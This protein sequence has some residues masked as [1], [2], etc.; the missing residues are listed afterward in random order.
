MVVVGVVTVLVVCG[1]IGSGSGG[2]VVVV[3]S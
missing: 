2:Y 1:E 3:E